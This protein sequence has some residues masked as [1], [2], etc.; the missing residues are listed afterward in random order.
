MSELNREFRIDSEYYQK[1]YLEDEIY[2]TYIGA[3][4][5]KCFIADGQHGYHELDVNSPIHMLTAKNAKNWFA[6]II[7]ADRVAKWVDESNKRSSLHENDLILSTRGTV[8]CCA[9]VKSEILPANLDQDLAR[10]KILDKSFKAEYVLVYLKCRFGQDW[11]KRNQTG[12]VQQGL[13][14]QKVREL[15]VPY[16]CEIFQDKIVALINYAHHL[17]NLSNYNY[18]LAGKFLTDCFD[19]NLYEN[20][21][22]S[23]VKSFLSSFKQSGRLDA[24]F[25]QPK[26]DL[27]Q[28]IINH[29]PNKPLKELAVVNTGEFVEEKFYGNIGIDYIRGADITN[30]VVDNSNAVKVNIDI[31]GLKTISYDDLAFAMIGSVGNVSIYKSSMVGLA[32]NN[33][34]IISPFDKHLSNYILLFLTSEIGRMLF[35]KYQTR[36]AQPKIRKEDVENFKIPLLDDETIKNISDKLEDSFRLRKE[37]KRLLDN[38]IKAVEMAIE[39]NEETALK[40][41]EKQNCAS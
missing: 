29:F 6:D 26:Y 14:L 15:P 36:T 18:S 10:I 2:L 23:S 40:W 33:L 21:E 35:E 3:E 19:I 12:M 31:N 7:G 30:P 11:M 20:K 25:Y 22:R 37:A 28:K 13:P 32:S 17:L 9:L 4:P 1:K 39:T 5:I 8:G 24:E 34:G 16:L 27:I 38:A 41:L